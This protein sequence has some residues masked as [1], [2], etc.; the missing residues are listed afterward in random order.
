MLRYNPDQ[1]YTK[2]YVDNEQ[3]IITLFEYEEYKASIAQH[4]WEVQRGMLPLYTVEDLPIIA[5]TLH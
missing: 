5:I 3:D 4:N 2:D 1:D